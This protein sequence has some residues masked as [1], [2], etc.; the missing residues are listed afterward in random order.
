MSLS[1]LL[2]ED[3]ITLLFE[4]TLHVNH[5]YSIIIRNPSGY[6]FI[7]ITI[8]NLTLALTHPNTI[9][10]TNKEL[11]LAAGMIKSYSGICTYVTKNTGKLLS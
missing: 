10:I 4:L 9:Y 11:K 8:T 2:L 1:N 5:Y 3:Y 7:M 6:K